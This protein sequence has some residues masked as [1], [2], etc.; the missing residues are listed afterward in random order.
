MPRDT[1]SKPYSLPD[2]PLE[3]DLQK[4]ALGTPFSNDYDYDSGLS[5][6][7]DKVPQITTSSPVTYVILATTTEKDQSTRHLLNDSLGSINIYTFQPSL[8]EFD[9]TVG[10]PDPINPST[11]PPETSSIPLFYSTRTKLPTLEDKQYAQIAEL[12][13]IATNLNISIDDQGLTTNNV[14]VSSSTASENTKVSSV[15][16]HEADNHPSYSV[17]N[18]QKILPTVVAVN[19]YRDNVAEA[20]SPVFATLS[21]SLPDWAWGLLGWSWPLITSILGYSLWE[22]L[23]LIK[24]LAKGNSIFPHLSHILK[25]HGR[26]NEPILSLRLVS[27]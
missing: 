8:K 17:D 9:S 21:T 2:V 15:A 25:F 1:A 20:S 14:L 10:N 13:Q 5:A 19:A 4:P 3:N 18:I 22:L 6:V 16:K 7:T 11:N 27:F 24:T 12:N 26:L 23:E